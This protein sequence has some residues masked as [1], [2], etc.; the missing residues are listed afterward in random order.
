MG[1]PA[2]SRRPA[3]MPAYTDDNADASHRRRTARWLDRAVRR[4]WRRRTWLRRRQ[5]H[6]CHDG[7]GRPRERGSQ[8]QGSRRWG[9]ERLRY[10]HSTAKC[11]ARCH[12]ST[13]AGPRRDDGHVERRAVSVRCPGR[14]GGAGRSD[15]SRT[16]WHTYATAAASPAAIRRGSTAVIT[17]DNNSTGLAVSNVAAGDCARNAARSV[18]AAGCRGGW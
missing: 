9:D 10:D 1:F 6:G 18:Q 8:P 5:R 17:A 15:C 11:W 14:S 16:E 2:I 4:G 7:C 13:R 3:R 12:A